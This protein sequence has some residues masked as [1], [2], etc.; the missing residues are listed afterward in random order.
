MLKNKEYMA[1]KNGEQTVTVGT[2]TAKNSRNRAVTT[3]HFGKYKF[4]KF[5]ASKI[6]HALDKLIE[7]EES[8]AE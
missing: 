2:K 6:A 7:R 1:C 3:Y 8:Y 5:Q 4:T